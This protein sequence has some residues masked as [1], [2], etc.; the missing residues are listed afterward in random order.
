MMVY[1]INNYSLFDATNDKMIDVLSV[2]LGKE[3]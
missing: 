2:K 1:L 3:N